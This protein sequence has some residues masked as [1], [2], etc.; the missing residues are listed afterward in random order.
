MHSRIPE[1]L[2]CTE[3]MYSKIFNPVE[4]SML[5]SLVN[6]KHGKSPASDQRRNE[7]LQK[8]IV[9]LYFSGYYVREG[10]RK[11]AVSF[12]KLMRTIKGFK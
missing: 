3:P 7:Y 12:S 11:S 5:D 8:V 6:D 10:D 4:L 1:Q 9:G 2:I